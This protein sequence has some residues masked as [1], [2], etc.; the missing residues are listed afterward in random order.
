MGWVRVRG[1]ERI[2]GDAGAVV[3]DQDRRWRL[4]G[5]I[6]NPVEAGARLT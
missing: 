2:L 6:A 3:M 4:V 1:A 5:K